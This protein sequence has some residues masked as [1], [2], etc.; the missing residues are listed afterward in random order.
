M[1]PTSGASFLVARWAARSYPD[2][3]VLALFADEGHRYQS[4]SG[5]E[6][7]LRERGLHLPV[8]PEGPVTVSDGAQVK[9]RWDRLAWGRR[10]RPGTSGPAV[11]ERAS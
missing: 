5:S 7:W 6:L 11:R 9:G 3:T 8:L 1:G 4:T 10:E 2:R